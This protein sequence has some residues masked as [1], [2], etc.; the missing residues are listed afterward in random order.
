MKNSLRYKV[1]STLCLCLSCLVFT[2]PSVVASTSSDPLTIV[3]PS[4]NSKVAAP[5]FTDP[6]PGNITVDCITDV[7]AMVSLMAEDDT[8]PAFPK[9]IMGVDSP[10][11]STINACIGG[12][13]TRT[14]TA[15]DMD[16]E[17]TSVSQTII[18]LPDT[19]APFLD[20]PP[21]RDTV[22]CE[23]SKGDAPNNS[24]RY[25]IWISSLRLAVAS[26]AIA[27]DNCSGIDDIDDNG[28]ASFD[29]DCATLTVVFT[30][31]DNCGL[32][33]QFVATYT[34]IDTVAPQLIGI[35]TETTLLLSCDDP[36][37]P[38]PTVTVSD[39]CDNTPDLNFSETNSQV[40]NGSCSEYEYSI[41]RTW[42]A[43]DN[44]GN[45]T[46]F[47]QTISIED[48]NAP[49]FTVP[50]NITIDCTQDP[51]DL[52]ITGDITDL[53]D[54]CT[55]T[56]SIRVFYN[57]TEEQGSC[58][59][60]KTIVRT[61]R[62]RDLCGNVTGKI[63]TIVVA[64]MQKPSFVAPPDITV[65][66]NQ[67]NDLDVTG[68]P[69]NVQ[70]N[71]DPMPVATFSDVVVDGLCADDRTIR[72]TW[73]LTD[74]CGNFQEH[75]QLITIKDQSAPVFEQEAQDITISCLDGIDIQ[76]VFMNWLSDR[77]GAT[78]EDNCADAEELIWTV[79]NSG[80]MDPPT[81]PSVACPS[82]SDTLLS[83]SVDFIVE[84]LCGNR[85]TTTAVFSLV[86]NNPPVLFCPEDITVNIDEGGCGATLTLTPPQISDECD[87][88]M[89][90]SVS[91]SDTAFITS[92][93]NPG[94]EGDIPV[95]AIDL[96]LVI[97]Q[98][99]PVNA[100]SDA[101][102][103][104]A[105]LSVDAEE[106][107][108]FFN[109][110]GEDGSLLGTTALTGAQCGNSE[111]QFTI[112]A[113]TINNWAVDGIIQ[114]H[115][116][117]NIPQGVEGKFAIN[118]ICNPPG[119][120]VASLAVDLKTLNGISYRYRIDQGP[121]ITVSPIANE[122]VTLDAGS[123]QITYYVSDCAG[124]IDS[125]AYEIMVIDTEPPVL[126]CPPD[127]V[128]SLAAD[129]CQKTVSLPL[130]LNAMDNC[131][132]FG[133]YT[134]Q[135]PL[136]TSSALISYT[137]DPNLTDYVANERTFNF[138]A[139]AA[140]AIGVATFNLSFKGDFNSN[141]AFVEV[142]GEDNS[143]L[144]QST[145]GDADCNTPGNLIITIPAA[146][147]NSWAA[148]GVLSIRVAP[149]EITVPPGVT[150]DG[151]NPCNPGAVTANGENDGSSY[152]FGTLNYLSLTPFY[153]AEGA[154]SIPLT[155]MQAP[156]LSPS[157][158]FNVGETEV[159]YII[160]DGSGN[161]DTCSFLITIE[162]TTPPIASCQTI[163]NLTVNPSGLDVEIFDVSDVNLASSDN[164]TIDTMF[165]TPSMFSCQDAGSTVNIT[166]TVR[167]AA[168]L[169]STCATTFGLTLERP[170]PIATPNLCGGDTL[171]LFAN[172]PG[173]GSQA[174]TYEWFLN[175]I[176]FSAAENP[177]I[178][179]VDPSFSGVYK[180]VIKGISGCRSEG[181][182]I[183]NVDEIT[184]RPQVTT[185]S[186]VCSVDDITLGVMDLPPDNNVSYHW[187]QGMPPNGTLLASTNEP[188]YTIPGP[189][190][191]GSRNFYL[192]VE[193]NGC[194]STPSNPIA[195]QTVEKP[196]AQVTFSDTTVCEG[197][198]I[199]LGT[200]TVG[201]GLVYHWTGP[202]DFSSAEQFPQIGP[203]DEL[204]EG[205]Y[206][207]S[208]LRNGCSSE[209]VSVELNIKAKPAKPN[210]TSNG[211]ICRGTTLALSTLT[212]GVSA[213]HWVQGGNGEFVS[214]NPTF[215]IPN[216]DEGDA[217][218]WQ[219]F[220]IKNG[221]ESD[222]SNPT[223]VTVNPRPTAG[224]AA[225]P[226]PVC[227]DGDIVLQGISD[228]GGVIFQWTGPGIENQQTIQNLTINN[229]SFL[230]QGTYDL[231]V[232]S[233]AGCSDTASV[234]VRVLEGISQ[235]D[236]SYTA[237][238]CFYAPS[239]VALT[240]LT[241]PQDNGSYTYKWSGPNNF[242]FQ[243]S[244]ATIPAAT[245]A[246]SG[247]YSVT[248][249][250]NQGCSVVESIFVELQDAPA[251]PAKPFT[252]SGN[253]AFCNGDKITLFTT[254]Y[255]IPGRDV[256]YFWQKGNGSMVT[257]TTRSLTIN[258]A[259][260]T[261]DGDYKVYV[262][263]D[264]CP[265]LTSDIST[266]TVHAIPNIEATSNSPVCRGENIRLSA[267]SSAGANYK[268]S[269]TGFEFSS[270]I[271][272]PSFNSDNQPGENG[273]YKVV[274]I[275]N[276]CPSDTA[277]VEVMVKP[278]P[279]IPV[280]VND[281]PHC[282]SDAEAALRLSLTTS[283][284]TPGANYSWFDGFSTLPLEEPDT[285]REFNFTDFTNYTTD[286][287]FPFYV[288]AT[289]NGCTAL[290]RDTTFAQLNLIPSSQAFA[291]VDTSICV[292]NYRLNAE[293]PSIGTGRWSFLSGGSGITI[294]NPESANTA[295]SGL[296][297]QEESYFFR[298]TLSNGACKNYSAD[299]IEIAVRQG[300][301]AISGEDILACEDEVVNLGAMPP[302][303]PGSIGT[304][305]QPEAQRIL[306]VKIND[307]N[308]AST[309][310]T[311]LEP[312]NVYIFTWTINTVCGRDSADVLVIISDP[313]PFAGL[314]E[315]VCNDEGISLLEAM[316]PTEGSHG[317]WSAV[318][319]KNLISD[320][321]NPQTM[322]SGL[323]PGENKFV[324]TIDEGFCGE[325]SRDTVVISYKTNPIANP[326][327]IAVDFQ[328]EVELDLLSNDILVPNTSIEIVSPPQQ[329]T[330]MID[331]QGKVNYIPPNNFVGMVEFLY[332]LVSEGCAMPTALVT[333][334]IGEDASCTAPSIIT[335]N[336]DGIND[337][338][339]VP[340]LLDQVTFS[341]SQVIIFNR[342]G[343]EVFRSKTPYSND[344]EGTYSG[345]NL[346]DGT[347]FYI[348]EYGNG[349]PPSNGFV[350]IQR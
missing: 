164:C 267:T 252:Q 46:I 51:T 293:M 210:I 264:D 17:M 303:E 190:S 287:L 122:T 273:I 19:E 288:V 42:M 168:G 279:K 24:L 54:N 329:G 318:N 38:F 25:D 342:W 195:V 48:D 321:D 20:I 130:P 326:D 334:L 40:A 345:E 62:A 12:T 87:L 5:V 199:N 313:Q 142:F 250:T 86:D 218:N 231:K 295:I 129:S 320:P 144:G 23:L 159:F 158:A 153:Y 173:P 208:I 304:W 63:Q 84:D 107:N 319:P 335:P 207:L 315:V 152:M 100:F 191:I 333:L 239:N 327:I 211:P 116:A 254:D 225:S 280:A 346:P 151:I 18:V 64:D 286:G 265:S 76:Q 281:G 157:H 73:K 132:A 223:L 61:W 172:P 155:S 291:G 192:I 124:N 103:K 28:P 194:M 44:C 31:T 56:D 102:L 262:V 322:I 241:F 308:N 221:C 2:T 15:T 282:I 148:D 184:Y 34:T 58:I 41:I 201:P 305:S 16:G 197:Q 243:G 81:L 317:L 32:N 170:A 176:F 341:S 104:I 242:Q 139:V 133:S 272:F 8:D 77:A 175:D 284:L 328:K 332:Q 256:T 82:P 39:N 336:G 94:Q 9:A 187:Y 310:I 30:L 101:L 14:W 27:S 290:R 93:A 274:A 348:I 145:V 65:N 178:P 226:N 232:T 246:Q 247:T 271:Q 167:D 228:L 340:C 47:K 301:E 162:D 174:Y 227:K 259:T 248:V 275:V 323:E 237:P 217:G 29:E 11:P 204:D 1:Q 6:T 21:F 95:N 269:A 7:P 108:E 146:T 138:N 205:F 169:E 156:S 55:P 344:W 68:R 255:N 45:T 120:V 309:L 347:Y 115:L 92:N 126:T 261:D 66:C 235:V 289:L 268:W 140:N 296:M 180:V 245:G 206:N 111:K 118:A 324:W 3:S 79:F 270:S 136:D 338:F 183:V 294:A 257:T 154:T 53:M 276:G 149:K 181:T 330:I 266:I 74:V 349:R 213:Y 163:G 224:A 188:T 96:N 198:T 72:R 166:L 314:D 253:L 113:F 85:D 110:Y 91:I 325:G 171:Y 119:R 215:N 249:T 202:N 13:I 307:R 350:L 311:G 285:S 339:V 185:V 219:L 200:F 26:N 57:D 67:A 117:P 22:A 135:L 316:P 134:Q 263:I 278:R 299:E 292:G 233:L 230:D 258:A 179:N 161:P 147:F 112:P 182:V 251:R 277:Q 49:T 106:A 10:E 71:C 283:S 229:A 331:G 160:E 141:N 137:L 302:M 52:N 177:I 297:R 36:V 234:F 127:M 143:L 150:G 75:D 186:T 222:L 90:Q 70:D 240:A 203:L 260:L 105:L 196:V 33:S 193:A 189:H 78:A 306:G 312:D 99:L 236:L 216:A 121:A 114:L 97:S 80:T 214:T 343:D 59:Y 98:P 88:S 220:V 300:E 37:P 337:A 238:N 123:H 83:Q 69:S 89:V 128:L 244:V 212:T 50:G 165:I 109:V 43:S 131:N 35:P 125:C 4:V 209:E 298:W 60:N